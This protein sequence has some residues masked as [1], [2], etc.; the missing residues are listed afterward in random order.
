MEWDE[1]ITNRETEEKDPT[2][3]RVEG[4]NW[5]SVAKHTVDSH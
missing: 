4:I 5:C 3:E 2:T 1:E